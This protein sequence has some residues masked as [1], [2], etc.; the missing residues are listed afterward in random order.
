MDREEL[1]ERLHDRG[2]W[3]S[4]FRRG[5][6]ADDVG[7][8]PAGG[9]YQ[10]FRPEPEDEVVRRGPAAGGPPPRIVDN[11]PPGFDERAAPPPPPVFQP[12]SPAYQPP[13]PP[14]APV[15]PPP[16]AAVEEPPA[17]PVPVEET[18]AELTV[19]A[20]APEPVEEP[21]PVVTEEPAAPAW[22]PPPPPSPPVYQPPAPAWEPPH[23]PP[24][25]A[26]E[27][28]SR[29]YAEEVVVASAPWGEDDDEFTPAGYR[30]YQDDDGRGGSIGPLMVGVFVVLGIIAVG[31]GAV[32]A[33]V[34]GNGTAQATPTPTPFVS[35]QATPS[36]TLEPTLEPT[37][38]PTAE[39]T[40][41]DGSPIVFPDGFT[42]Q[43]QPCAEQPESFDG[44]DSSGSTVTG[45]AMWVWIG[46]RNGNDADI[47][48]VTIVDSTNQT[49][50]EGDVELS[51]I[52]CGDSCNGWLR[53]RFGDLD[54]GSYGIRIQRNGLPAAE[55]SFTVV[56]G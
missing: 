26:Y 46:F 55:S 21:E 9:A 18:A 12:P 48:S 34:F 15:E 28:D 1:D 16:V 38:S 50:A 32:L 44:C 53:F 23:T 31:F 22:E 5:R 37:A 20:E 45:D 52:D 30:Q 29:R 49:V 43:T 2:G 47:V 42:A 36:P 40:P 56:A 17:P 7:R 51:I 10:P 6:D 8:G 13:P 39:P 41:G 4:S 3:G 33:G 35:Q 19:E 27:A 14:P 11:T 25:P 24:L 54:P